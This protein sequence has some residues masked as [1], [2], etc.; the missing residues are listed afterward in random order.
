MSE[1]DPYIGLSCS[2]EIW[3]EGYIIGILNMNLNVLSRTEAAPLLQ[4]T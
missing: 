2:I 3:F 4:D 1:V